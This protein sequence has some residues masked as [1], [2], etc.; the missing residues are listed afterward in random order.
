MQLENN[1]SRLN[2]D[3]VDFKK[4]PIEKHEKSG[5]FQEQTNNKC[6]RTCSVKFLFMQLDKDQ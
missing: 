1:I 3:D 2:K 6:K 4:N 5:F